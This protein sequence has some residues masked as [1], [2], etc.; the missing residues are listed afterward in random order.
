MLRYIYANFDGA[1]K[2]INERN[3]EKCSAYDE[4][5]T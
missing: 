4:Q 5:V 2:F 3:E 1:G